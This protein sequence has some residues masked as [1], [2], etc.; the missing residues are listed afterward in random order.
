VAG[1]C[2]AVRQHA[3]GRCVQCD[4]CEVVTGRVHV[5]D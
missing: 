4:C 3:S 1:Q 5:V 2:M